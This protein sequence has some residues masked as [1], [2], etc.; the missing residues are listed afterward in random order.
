MVRVERGVDN[1][2][3]RRTALTEPFSFFSSPGE[4]TRE[5]FLTALPLLGRNRAPTGILP[6]DELALLDTPR[7]E[8][9]FEHLDEMVRNGSEGAYRDVRVFLGEWGV[10]ERA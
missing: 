5:A 10:N 3:R 6:D 9:F 7:F 1:R 4:S 8:G 2:N